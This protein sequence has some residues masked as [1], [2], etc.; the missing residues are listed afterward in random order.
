MNSE[1]NFFNQDTI[2]IA[3][4]LLG[5]Q[6]VR[7]TETH[8]YR[9]IITETEGYL[10]DDLANHARRGKTARTAPLF[11]KAGTI[12]VY[13]IYGMYYCLNIVTG[14]KGIP[15]AVLIRGL[16]LEKPYS[17]PLNGPGKVCRELAITSTFSGLNLGE[18][19]GLWLEPGIAAHETNTTARIG[20]QYAPEPWRSAPLRFVLQ[21]KA[22]G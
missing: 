4:S 17:K 20:I 10:A 6:L 3:R 5:M 2:S 1:N 18:E 12:Y 9:G 13:H 8:T 16:R 22:E 21:E 14:Q 11:E 19:T 7:R 15:E